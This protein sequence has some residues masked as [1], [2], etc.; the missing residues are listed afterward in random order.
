MPECRTAL[1]SFDAASGEWGAGTQVYG[2]V[3]ERQIEFRSIWIGDSAQ[4]SGLNET[5]RATQT[6]EGRMIADV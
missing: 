1:G 4:A 3:G 2:E 6:V 5:T